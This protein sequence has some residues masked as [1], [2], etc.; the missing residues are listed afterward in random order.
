MSTNVM[1]LGE[2][3][4]NLWE[5]IKHVSSVIPYKSLDKQMNLKLRNQYSVSTDYK[6]YSLPKSL[7]KAKNYKG[8]EIKA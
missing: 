6:N 4:N 2:E 3:N 5:D 1:E 8:P 7:I